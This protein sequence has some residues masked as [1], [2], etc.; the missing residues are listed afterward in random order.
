[1]ATEPRI[2]TKIAKRRQELGMT[3]QGLAD[4][5]GVSKSTVA[6]WESGKHF[7]LRK[8]GKVESVLGVSLTGGQPPPPASRG[9]LADQL[10]RM[11]RQLRA[12][13]EE[14]DPDEQGN[15]A[16]LRRKAASGG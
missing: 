12:Q 6:N 10:E 4:E 2:G 15:G 11:A 8:L 3:Q 14:E 5:L 9:D 1:M 16:P 7:P 13:M